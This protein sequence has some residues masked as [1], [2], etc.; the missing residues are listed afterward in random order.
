MQPVVKTVVISSPRTISK[1]DTWL[2]YY[3][4][5]WWAQ[6]TLT[7]PSDHALTLRVIRCRGERAKRDRLAVSLEGGCR[8]RCST[9]GPHWRYR[10]HRGSPVRKSIG[11]NYSRPG[12]LVRRSPGLGYRGDRRRHG[13]HIDRIPRRNT[14]RAQHLDGGRERADIEASRRSACRLS[15]TRGAI[16]GPRAVCGRIDW[17][18]PRRLIWW[19]EAHITR[20]GRSAVDD[21]ASHSKCRAP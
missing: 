21:R 19:T 5:S 13:A 4:Q 1:S 3:S 16:D 2:I 10:N 17:G 20:T 18:G 9:R 15:G 12:D 14:G 11:R 7:R 8:N 6:P